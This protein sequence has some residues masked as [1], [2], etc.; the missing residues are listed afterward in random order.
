MILFLL[1]EVMH[2]G[3][4]GRSKVSRRKKEERKKVKGLLKGMWEWR[5]NAKY[6]L[7]TGRKN[8]KAAGSRLAAQKYKAGLNNNQKG[9]SV[10][11]ELTQLLWL[12]LQSRREDHLDGGIF[13]YFYIFLCL[14]LLWLR[15]RLVI[16]GQYER[17]H[18]H[19]IGWWMDGVN[20]QL[21][22]KEST[23]CR[24]YVVPLV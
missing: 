1:R 9:K 15:R 6:G 24:Q 16:C 23:K 2:K 14:K 4:E 19:W 11:R 18:R 5:S 7:A 8:I 3:V 21:G 17:A 22:R 10:E 12:K 13:F 20:V